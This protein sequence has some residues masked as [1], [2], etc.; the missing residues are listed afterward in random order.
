MKK[1]D[2]IK[3]LFKYIP[4]DS[5]V[6]CAT[7]MISREV[8]DAAERET[9]FYMIGSMSYNS[10][11]GIGVA[12]NNTGKKVFI[13]D[14]DGSALMNMGNLALV[15]YL[16]LENYYHIVL[17]NETYSSTGGQKCISST[18]ELEKIAGSAG[19]KKSYKF[20]DISVIEQEFPK[21]LNE[22]GPVF[23]LVK[24]ETGNLEDIARVTYTPQQI[25]DRFKRSIA[26]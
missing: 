22:K 8:F 2:V 17:D 12:L 6:I 1:I 19:Y 15:G 25:R 9:N 4:E 18:A 26:G 20:T 10:S 3:S 14:G 23:I 16:G 7:G 24:V 5:P 11:I 13:M 21:I